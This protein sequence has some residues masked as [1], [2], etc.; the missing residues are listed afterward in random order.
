MSDKI[1]INLPITTIAFNNTSEYGIPAAGW[2][3]AADVAKFRGSFEIRG[4]N[5]V[6]NVALGYQTCDV[7]NSVDTPVAVTSYQTSNGMYYGTAFTDISANT[8]GKQWVRIVWMVKLTS[9]STLATASV[10]GSV[11]LL[12]P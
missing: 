8:L 11:D 6:L 10:S 12:T 4:I 2:M 1:T 7:P 9:G 3:R 5:G